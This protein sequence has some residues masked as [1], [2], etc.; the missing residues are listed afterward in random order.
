MWIPWPITSAPASGCNRNEATS[1]RV[2][3]RDL[4]FFRRDLSKD[5]RDWLDPEPAWRKGFRKDCLSPWRA[6]QEA[7]ALR[8][9]AREQGRQADGGPDPLAPRLLGQQ[10]R[11]LWLEP[12]RGIRLYDLIRLLEACAA[13]EST[14][15]IQTLLEHS[16]RRLERLQRHLLGWQGPAGLHPYPLGR[17]VAGLVHLL[18]RLLE[19]PPLEQELRG[20][21]RQLSEQWRAW[22]VLPFRDATSKNVLVLIPELDPQHGDLQRLLW[23]QRQLRQWPLQH[24]Q[25]LPMRDLDF[26]SLLHST[27]PEDDPISLLAH[28]RTLPYSSLSAA[29][30]VLLPEC[31]GIEPERAALGLLVRWL[32]FG[33]RKL[34]YRL[35]HPEACSRRFRHDAPLPYFS[36]I[37]RQLRLLDP[38]FERR[39]PHLLERLEAIGGAYG[40]LPM[41]AAAAG[42][43]YLARF[44]Q[45]RQLWQESPLVGIALHG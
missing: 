41:Q 20:E 4:Q 27:V 44:P 43:A 38:E 5:E 40:G 16:R 17:K 2:S 31:F 22:A 11:H 10:G 18:S 7:A 35:L 19:L 42:D 45:R 15:V 26:S 36:T 30:L 1:V 23:L 32:R 13:Q 21:L 33:G 14:A 3:E 28:Q 9:M 12:L 37:R 8:H 29:D 24:W 39:I 34:A 6:E 25:Q